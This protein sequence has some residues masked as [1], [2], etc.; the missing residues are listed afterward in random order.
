MNTHSHYQRTTSESRD[1]RFKVFGARSVASVTPSTE[2]NKDLGKK[3]SPS[4]MMIQQS[5]VVI[6]T[7][8]PGTPGF[9]PTFQPPFYPY[10]PGFHPFVQV[11]MIT[12]HLVNAAIQ[13]QMP[14]SEDSVKKKLDALSEM[15]VKLQNKFDKTEE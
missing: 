12:P 15:V 8:A 5:P 6:N 13:P 4:P 7:N 2:V 9:W 14:V 11:P 3:I 1:E 10:P